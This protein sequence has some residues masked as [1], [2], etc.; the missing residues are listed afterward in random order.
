MILKDKDYKLIE[1]YFYVCDKFEDGLEFCCQRFS[2]NDSPDFTDK[3][4]ITLYLYVMHHE[5][6]FKVKH[7]HRFAHEYL[8]SWFPE[9]PSYQAFNNRI[10]RLSA[11]LSGLTELLLTENQPDDCFSDQS[12]LD[13][14]P[15]IT[16]SGKRKGKVATEITDKGYCATKGFYYSDSSCTLWH[17]AAPTDC[18]IRNRSCS[19]RPRPMT[20]PC[21]NRRGRNWEA[22]RSSLT[23]HI[24]IMASTRT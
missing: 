18:H 19:P 24:M 8:R 5:Q 15:V 20:F 21:S 22:G 7:I 13:S 9:L 10:N 6:Q 2:N 4:V 23:R 11:A 14:M 1:I 16:C 12:L 3:E 17:S